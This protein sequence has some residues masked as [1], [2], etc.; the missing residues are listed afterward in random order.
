M[1]GA[2]VG[3]MLAFAVWPG[4]AADQPSFRR[5]ISGQPAYPRREMWHPGL[6]RGLQNAAFHCSVSTNQRSS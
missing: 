1:N 6:I 5:D 2:M 3:P 4:R